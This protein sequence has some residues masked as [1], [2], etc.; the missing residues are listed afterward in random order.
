[1]AASIRPL[2]GT[3]KTVLVRKPMDEL[4]RLRRWGPRPYFRIEAWKRQ[5]EEAVYELPELQPED[6]ALPPIQVWFLTGRRF[7]YQ[8][9]F[10][11][12]SLAHH[13]QRPLE[14]HL[15]DDGSL[16]AE[17]ERELR[18]LFPAG[19]TRWKAE[20]AA[21]LDRLL[22]RSRFPVLRERCSDYINIRK[23]TDIHLGSSGIKLVLDSDMLFFAPPSQLLAWW[24]HPQGICLMTDCQESY[25]YSRDLLEALAGA[26]IPPLLNVGICGLASD[27]I[28][29]H[30]L[31]Y[32]CSS[33][34]ERQGT[35]YFLEQALVA[36]MAA[37]IGATVMPPVSYITF[38]TRQ[39]AEAGSG[40]MQH[41]VADSK[42]WYFKNAWRVCVGT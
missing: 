28:D 29:W 17:Q 9:A 16:E 41:Y 3:A 2:L 14:L 5:M 27:S 7:W 8:T 21:Q 25:G 19:L 31:E 4:A 42:P 35:S 18:R 6:D 39:Q 22:P 36:M 33:L 12:W 40:V 1:M 34:L 13:A 10:C 32:W 37:R 30:E 23:L 20:S 24:D 11:A 38:P 26:P 15:V